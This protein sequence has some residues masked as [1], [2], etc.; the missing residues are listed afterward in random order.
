[1]PG[2]RVAVFVTISG[3]PSLPEKWLALLLRKPVTA[4]IVSIEEDG[5]ERVATIDKGSRAGLKVGMR[6]IGQNEEPSPWSV[7]ELIV[8]EEKSA[9]LRVGPASK[10]GEKLTTRYEPRDRYR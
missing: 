10:V 6:L 1:M 8:V 2:V 7:S 3:S 5:Q 4:T 9:K